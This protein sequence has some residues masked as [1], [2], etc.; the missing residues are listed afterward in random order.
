[1]RPD[2]MIDLSRRMAENQYDEKT[3]PEG[4]VD[5]GSALNDLMEDDLAPWVGQQLE[6]LPTSQR[7]FLS[8][9]GQI[10][11]TETRC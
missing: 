11:R 9:P 7:T 8:P 2:L 5:L 6:S 3:N 4:I 1:M 10:L